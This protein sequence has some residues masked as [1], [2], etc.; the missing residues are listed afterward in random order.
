MMIEK[1]KKYNIPQEIL[2]SVCLTAWNLCN[3]NREKFAKM[4]G[5][6]TEA[7]IANAIASVENAKELPCLT[8]TN[9]GRK[10]ARIRLAKAAR[11]V[12]DNWQVLKLYATSAF[13]KS[14]ISVVLEQAGS[15]FYKK[16]SLYNWSAVR[17]MIDEANIF[18]RNNKEALTANNNMPEDFQTQFAADG[19]KCLQLSMEFFSL[20][21]E[22]E[23]TTYLKI[24]ANNAIYERTIAMLKDGQRIFSDDAVN[25]RQFVFNYL[26]SFQRGQGTASLKGYITDQL[27]LPV[28]GVIVI[29][30]NEKYSATTDSRGYYQISRMAHGSYLFHFRKPGYQSIE[31]PITLTEG[32][33]A[34]GDFIMKKQMQL[35]A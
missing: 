27:N 24:A 25:K 5:F 17:T 9:A 26:V 30:E 13:D 31:Q 28:E 3:E 34:K 33:S 16:A 22:K 4:K 1:N 29:S 2:Y 35:V 32:T 10:V 21:L 6:Y 19:D 20:N 23:K 8:Q 7:F 18:I 12:M 11:Q 15:T 14:M